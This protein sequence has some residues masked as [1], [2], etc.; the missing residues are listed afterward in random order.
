MFWE[1]EEKYGELEEMNVLDNLG[2][3]LVGNV[4]L[5][6]KFEECA[7]AVRRPLPLNL[8]SLQACIISPAMLLSPDTQ[9]V[10]PWPCH[11]PVREGCQQPVV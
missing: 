7:E 11:H 1:M 8:L 2:D 10:P 9:L 3:H 6:F 4:Y 5:M